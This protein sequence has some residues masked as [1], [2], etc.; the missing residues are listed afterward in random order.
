MEVA[1]PREEFVPQIQE[2]GR[3]PAIHA[4]AEGASFLCFS[5]EPVSGRAVSE[6]GL[7]DFG[8][9]IAIFLSPNKDYHGS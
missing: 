8:A 9:P 6:M 4:P 5:T 7:F 3:S 2:R 1:V